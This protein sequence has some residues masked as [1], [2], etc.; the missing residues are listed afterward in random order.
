M[1]IHDDYQIVHDYHR[2][3]PFGPSNSSR[4]YYSGM[5]IHGVK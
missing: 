3:L 5:D 2:W 1:D 4:V